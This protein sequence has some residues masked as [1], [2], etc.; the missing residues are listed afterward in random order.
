MTPDGVS[1][2]D[3]GLLLHEFKFN[4]AKKYSGADLLK[5]KTVWMWQGM[6][7]VWGTALT[8]SCGTLCL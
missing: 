8:G 2:E 5:K 3:Y 1:V 7:T 4:R 6:V